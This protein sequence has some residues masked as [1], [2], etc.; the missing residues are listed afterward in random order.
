MKK[1]FVLTI[2]VIGLSLCIVGC[3]EEKEEKDTTPPT[4]S[5]LSNDPLVLDLG[6]KT[7]AMEGI[8]AIDDVDGD[9]TKSITLLTELETIGSLTL[10]YTVSDA[11]KNTAT[12]ERPAIIR[13]GK[14]AGEY[15]VSILSEDS[16]P[17]GTYTITIS[18]RDTVNLTIKNLHNK[19]TWASVPLFPAEPGKME[20]KA[21]GSFYDDKEGSDYKKITGEVLYENVNGKYLITSLKYTLDPEDSGKKQSFSSSKCELKP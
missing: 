7:A 3:K 12:A 13:S 8:T 6:D 16:V 4:I 14:L 20:I 17:Y 18:E 10:K 9:I 5:F 11:A 2:T 1:V 15:D 21:T 19:S